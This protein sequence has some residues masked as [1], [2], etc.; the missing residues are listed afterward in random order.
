MSQTLQFTMIR[1]FL[2]S[3]T[4]WSGDVCCSMILNYLGCQRPRLFISAA[5]SDASDRTLRIRCKRENNLWYP[6]QSR[7]DVENSGC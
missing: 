6:G 3:V 4:R 2:D 1:Y 7:L 5:Y